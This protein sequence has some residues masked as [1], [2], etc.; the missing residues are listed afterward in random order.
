[1][2][3]QRN[4]IQS[5]YDLRSRDTDLCL[6]KPNSVF[7]MK[8]EMQMIQASSDGLFEISVWHNIVEDVK[9]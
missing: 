9:S 3:L 2:F 1:V 8:T 5:N 6:P 4:T 7:L